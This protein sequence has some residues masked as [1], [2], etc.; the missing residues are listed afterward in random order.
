MDEHPEITIDEL[1]AQVRA[2]P[3]FSEFSDERIRLNIERDPTW[4]ER[5]RSMIKE[6]TEI[7]EAYAVAIAPVIADLK[8]RGIDIDDIYKL[9]HRSRAEYLAA[10]PI[11]TKWVPRIEYMF[12]KE[13]VVR[14][15]SQ[16][17]AT[18]AYPIFLREFKRMR[19]EPPSKLRWAY[20]NGLEIFATYERADE[21]LALAADRQYAND[22]AQIIHSLLRIKNDPRVYDTIVAQLDDASVE[23]WTVM[24]LRS[25]ADP[26]TRDVLERYL[27]H[28]D[29]WVR[30]HAKAGIKKIDTKIAKAGGRPRPQPSTR[31]RKAASPQ[32]Q[33]PWPSGLPHD[34]LVALLFANLI[35]LRALAG[36]SE[37]A[38]LAMDGVGPKTIERI[39]TELRERGLAP[40]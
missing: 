30:N 28:P 35:D 13:A 24:T 9:P 8:A 10:V 15:L 5:Y 12:A 14:A 34:A 39:K 31:P 17:I 26:R 6:R 27:A 18:E 32:D 7:R 22:R 4:P 36:Y 21:Y 2:D 23:K 25:L 38:L 16:S 20:G 11:L 33:R 1:V 37:S 19:N 29:S 40:L 3:I